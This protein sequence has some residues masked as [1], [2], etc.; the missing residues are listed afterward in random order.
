MNSS[1]GS[2]GVTAGSLASADP[3]TRKYLFDKKDA[4]PRCPG[5]LTILFSAFPENET[6]SPSP[7]LEAM[8]SGRT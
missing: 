6:R 1:F 2:S 8:S 3:S 7:T 4:G 5:S